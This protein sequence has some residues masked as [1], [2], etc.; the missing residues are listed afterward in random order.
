MTL[1]FTRAIHVPDADGTQITTGI[2]PDGEVYLLILDGTGA[3]R[4]TPEL[5][6]KLAVILQDC[7]QRARNGGVRS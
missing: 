3:A 2:T 7:A 5:A 4:L 6:G 1:N